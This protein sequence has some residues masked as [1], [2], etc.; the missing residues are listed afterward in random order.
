MKE[1]DYLIKNIKGEKSMLRR[2]VLE[3]PAELSDEDL[4]DKDVQNS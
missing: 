1:Y 3:F 4:H 2:L